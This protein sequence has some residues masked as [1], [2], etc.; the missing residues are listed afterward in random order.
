MKRTYLR[1]GMVGG[2]IGSIIGDVHRAAISLCG[3]A[4]LTAGCFSRDMAKNRECAEA[5]RMDTSRLYPDYRT[6]AERESEC[7]D[8][9]DFVVI[10]TPNSTHYETA[11]CF[12]EHGFHVVCEKPLCFT[13]AEA[14]ELMELS[15]ERGKLFCVTYTYTGYNIIKYARDMVREGRIGEV[16]HVQAEYL[17]D[18]LVDALDSPGD[19]GVWRLDPAK[20][21]KSCCTGDIGTHLEALAAYVTGQRVERVAARLERYGK[22]L[23]LG[24]DLLVGFD[25]GADGVFTASQVSIGC[26]NGIRLR[27][28]GTRGALEWYQEEPERLWYTP[29]GGNRQCIQ[30]GMACVTGR[31]AALKRLPAG[32][33]EGFITAF[34][35]IYEG[36]TTSVLKLANGETPDADD[37]DFPDAAWGM[38]GVKFID[39]VVKSDKNGSAWTNL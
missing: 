10:A 11:K 3:T 20:A 8:G 23:D 18:W 39:A 26:L 6:M 12:L 17:Q 24:M 9:I 2:G 14:E 30:R 19:G 33:P 27:V 31:A 32:H 35:N 37:L 34:A 4:E 16:L 13:A 15:R 7:A 29:R 28:F 25:G 36:F 38:Y 21:G 1:Y 22:A 5:C